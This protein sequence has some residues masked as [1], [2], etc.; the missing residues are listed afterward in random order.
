MPNQNVR[1]RYNYTRNPAYNNKV[2]IQYRSTIPG[3][4]NVSIADVSVDAVN[5]Q[6]YTV[7]IPAVTNYNYFGIEVDDPFK[8]F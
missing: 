3:D 5:Q 2:T 8:L 6:S 7:P 4:S 1:V